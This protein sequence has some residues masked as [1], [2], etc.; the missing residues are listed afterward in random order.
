MDAPLVVGAPRSGAPGHDVD[1][2]SHTLPARSNTP[3]RDAGIDAI[4]AVPVPGQ[5]LLGGRP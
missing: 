4:E 3:E 5:A 2:H 1:V